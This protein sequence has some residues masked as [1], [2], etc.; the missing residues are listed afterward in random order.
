M[1]THD[2]YKARDTIRATMIAQ[3]RALDDTQRTDA[4]H[5]LADTLLA[6]RDWENQTIAVYAA[7]DGEIDLCPFLRTLTSH[8]TVAWPVSRADGVMEFREAP[9]EDLV[10][11]KY[12]I[13]E[14]KNGPLLAPEALDAMLIP[15]SAFSLNGG[16]LGM[17]GG[18]Y[19][20][21]LVHVPDHIPQIG[22]A[23]HWQIQEGFSLLPHDIPMTHLATDSG[24]FPCAM[25]PGT[26]QPETTPH[27]TI[28]K[29]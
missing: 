27:S 12:G 23:Y 17:G 19:D 29:P 4:S 7:Y 1:T 5:A 14:P 26:T 18:Y 20:R 15:G 3:R 10:P 6:A 16:R 8:I 25:P 24:W 21:Y 11:G 28:L 9:F 22:V 13:L 2:P